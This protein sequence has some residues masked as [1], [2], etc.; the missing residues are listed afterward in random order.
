M[1]MEAYLHGT[2]ARK[3]DDLVKALGVGSGIS[4]T[5]ASRICADLDT[6]IAV[7]QDRSLA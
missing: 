2:S 6:E 7:V 5:E 3:V 1:I 4:K